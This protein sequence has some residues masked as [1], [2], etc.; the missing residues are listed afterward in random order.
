MVLLVEAICD[1]DRLLLLER[2]FGATQA[3][4]SQK[5]QLKASQ[6]VIEPGGSLMVVKLCSPSVSRGHHQ[7]VLP[8]M[9]SKDL[10]GQGSCL[11]VMAFS[12]GKIVVLSCICFRVLCDQ[13]KSSSEEA[14]YTMCPD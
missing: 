2:R 9:P 14:Y 10:R 3:E 8:T 5:Q 12:A 11:M 1:E 13:S 7:S 6:A 4:Q